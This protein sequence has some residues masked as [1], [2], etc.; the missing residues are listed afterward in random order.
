M[1]SLHLQKRRRLL[2]SA[3]VAAITIIPTLGIA[4]NKIVAVND[5]SAVTYTIP[6]G[7]T[8]ITDENFYDCVA[9]TYL[10][11]H[12][13][14]DISTGLSDAQLA[15]I[16]ALNCNKDSETPNEEK[17]FNTVGLEK[18]TGLT[19]LSLSYNHLTGS[20]LDI[21][22]NTALTRLDVDHN[23]LTTLDVSHNTALTEL[24]AFNNN[25]NTLNISSSNTT[26]TKIH[27]Y[28]NALAS[29]DV[30]GATALTELYV[31]NNVL[32][33][34]DT[35]HN[36]ALM[37]L[38]ATRNFLTSINVSQNPNLVSLNVGNNQLTSLNVSNNTNL[39]MLVA[40]SN[41]LSSIDVS[42]N[43]A[44]TLL[45]VSSNQLTSLNVSNNTNLTELLVN[46]NQLTALDISHNASLN[47]L[48]ADN[49]LVWA[50]LGNLT[51]V[52]PD[53]TVNLTGLG[54]LK[55]N[56][57]VNNTDS[58]TYDGANKTVTISDPSGT[59]GYIQLS[60]PTVARTYKL[61]LPEFLVFDANGGNGE[62]ETLTC[63]RGFNATACS[64][65]LPGT[66]PVYEDHNFLGWGNS[67]SDNSGTY[68]PGNTVALTGSKTIYAIWAPMRTLSFELNEGTGE[69]ESQTCYPSTAT[70]SC[71]VTIPEAEIARDGYN[72]L[73]WGS[74]ADATSG[75]Y[76]AG[77][78][79]T[80][81]ADKTVYAVWQEPI[82]DPEPEPEPES[83]PEAD[84]ENIPVPDT[85][86]NAGKE[87][88]SASIILCGLLATAASA[89]GLLIYRHRKNTADLIY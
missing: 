53:I 66:E 87:G 42:H 5:A 1:L 11:S 35:T 55:S 67:A 46:S 77:D 28:E 30:S 18:M 44:L 70:G 65:T 72:F 20:T 26:L 4:I 9:S 6:T 50:N 59:S 41:Q 32:E 27:V 69:I 39:N 24:Y 73:G 80:L 57:T 36:P 33:S 51:S 54:F 3:T 64:V 43:T 34:L 22:H 58:Y 40:V 78:N 86:V 52:E 82:P 62:F 37:R 17:I 45:N 47:S 29:I 89:T 23:Y 13:S 48:S 49:I 16:T 83:E 60:S 74:S 71:R 21:S 2:L 7:Y 31:Y 81:S 14:A 19:Q 38:I 56:Q 68:Q 85:G 10:D 12:P 8:T 79:V 15:E 76:Q 75:A 25:L 61:K 84:S 63:S 88:N